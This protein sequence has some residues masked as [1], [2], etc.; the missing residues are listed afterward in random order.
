M[1]HSQADVD[2]FEAPQMAEEQK[3]AFEVRYPLISRLSNTDFLFP[4]PF[5]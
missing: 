2:A 5:P 3:L 4:I 1:I